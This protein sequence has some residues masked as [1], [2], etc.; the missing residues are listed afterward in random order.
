MTTFN[1]VPVDETAGRFA[2]D[3][4]DGRLIQVRV[5]A[6]VKAGVGGPGCSTSARFTTVAR[7]SDRVR[8]TST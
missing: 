2:Q 5:A 6:A 1:A 8:L 4:A 7:R 3:H